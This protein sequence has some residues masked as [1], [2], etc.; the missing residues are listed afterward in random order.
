VKRLLL[1]FCLVLLVACQRV[2]VNPPA[3]T[4]APTTPTHIE[5][6]P[7][8]LVRAV[9]LIDDREIELH[10]DKVNVLPRMGVGIVLHFSALVR[11]SNETG[12]RECYGGIYELAYSTPNDLYDMAGNA[13]PQYHFEFRV[14]PNAQWLSGSL[15]EELT[16][17][18]YTLL[19]P[20][21]YMRLELPV[22]I[23]QE[24][25]TKQL[26]QDFKGAKYV[27]Q[28]EGPS[29]VLLSL[30][31]T[32]ATYL[33]IYIGRRDIP[34]WEINAVPQQ[35][36]LIL[37]AQ[38]DVLASYNVPISSAGAISM[39]NDFSAVRLL[40]PRYFG[41]LHAPLQEYVWD[42]DNGEVAVADEPIMLASDE[43][44]SFDSKQALAKALTSLE[45]PPRMVTGLSNDQGKIAGYSSGEV[46]VIDLTI[47]QLT[48]YSIKSSEADAAHG[49]LPDRV[50]WSPD[51]T[52]LLYSALP[53]TRDILSLHTL[54]L[55]SGEET[56]IAQGHDLKLASPYSKHAL[57]TSHNSGAQSFHMIDY[58][59]G[60]QVQLNALGEQVILAKWIDSN[61]ALINKGVANTGHVN[62]DLT[63]YIYH[64]NENRWEY[65]CEGYGFDYDAATGR[66][67]V[68]QNR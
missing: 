7:A 2:A 44:S 34:M 5:N 43:Y 39:N 17:G 35:R 22:E 51:D 41:W 14:V 66:V 16:Q 63:C 55:V 26:A 52:M 68:L 56:L 47:Q 8:E 61:R 4:P 19:M 21:E 38:S 65:I 57:T 36:L 48:S 10:T 53:S 15:R 31:D 33:P 59:S 23:T 42:I 62:S 54:D 49:S 11:R 46:K 1:T 24:A 13:V 29:T 45:S 37:D 64:L 50:L 67:F 18:G 3:V 30:Q 28:W 6:K 25:F 40:R 60:H 27:A 32:S 58:A 12:S 20:G 9:A